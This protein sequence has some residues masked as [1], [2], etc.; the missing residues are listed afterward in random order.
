MESFLIILTWLSLAGMVL[1]FVLAFVKGKGNRRRNFAK[2]GGCLIALIVISLIG[3]S[4]SE[5]KPA[6]DPSSETAAQEEE[7]T[8]EAEEQ[9]QKEKEEQ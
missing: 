8:Q 4:I 6:T 7:K 3:A 5:E 1:F 9:A 2:S